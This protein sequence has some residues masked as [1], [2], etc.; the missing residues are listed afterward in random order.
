MNAPQLCYSD[1]RQSQETQAHSGTQPIY[2]YQ[3]K[4]YPPKKTLISIFFQIQSLVFVLSLKFTTFQGFQ[5]PVGF[6]WYQVLFLK[7]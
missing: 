6:L 5:G 7:Q 3:V 1:G 4:K 2:Q